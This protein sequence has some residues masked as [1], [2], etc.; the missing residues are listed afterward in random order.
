MWSCL[1]VNFGVFSACLPSLTPL[2]RFVYGKSKPT[3]HSHQDYTRQRDD[4]T[5][6]RTFGSAG[7]PGRPSESLED[8]IESRA[9]LDRHPGFELTEIP[10][11]SANGIMV[12]RQVDVIE[13]EAPTKK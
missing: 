7:N 8:M 4:E 6:I 11:N 13:S 2:I 5:R 3:K 1:E 12:T 10:E 9:G